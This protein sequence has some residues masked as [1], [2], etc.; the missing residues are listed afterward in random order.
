M[1]RIHL[2]FVL[3]LVGCSSSTTTLEEGTMTTQLEAPRLASALDTQ[4]AKWSAEGL[5]QHTQRR[6][7]E[8]FRRDCA[9]VSHAIERWCHRGPHLCLYTRFSP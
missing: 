3:G 4:V 1:T 2:V 8:E 6:S 5:P 7:S 9:V